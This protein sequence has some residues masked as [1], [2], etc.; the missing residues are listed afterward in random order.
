MDGD[1]WERREEKARLVGLAGGCKAFLWAAAQMRDGIAGS[2]GRR[3][4]LPNQMQVSFLALAWHRL[5]TGVS[6]HTQ[7]SSM[8]PRLLHVPPAL[9]ALPA[10]SWSLAWKAQL[11]FY[12]DFTNWFHGCHNGTGI[13]KE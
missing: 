10:S 9:A 1:G 5:G 11:D 8:A 4:Y 12:S 13:L 2:H 3:R 7:A 6:R